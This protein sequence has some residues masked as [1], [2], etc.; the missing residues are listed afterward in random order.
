MI[1]QPESNGT[2]PE[3]EQTAV[4]NIRQ[5]ILI[6][7]QKIRQLRDAERQINNEIKAA[8]TSKSQVIQ[9]TET[10]EESRKTLERDIKPL[11]DEVSETT[12]ERNDLKNEIAELIVQK[13]ELELEIISK[14]LSI[15]KELK[16]LNLQKDEHALVTSK[17]AEDKK[18][19]EAKVQRLINALK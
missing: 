5:E 2:I 17:L 14:K 13:K 15:E 11:I 18:D 10:L 12:V 9:A 16:L 6:G 3:K 19:H 8:L 1:T 4:A 7:E